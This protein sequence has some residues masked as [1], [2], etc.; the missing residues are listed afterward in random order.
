M[1]H[2]LRSLLTMLGVVFGVG[3]V[4]AMLAVGE[5]ANAEALKQIRELGSNNIIL[6]S[7]KPRKERGNELEGEGAL[8][9][10]LTYD[11]LDRIKASMGHIK[12]IVP[13][14]FSERQGRLKRHYGDVR[15]VGA[16]PDWFNV[17]YRPLLAGR[18][19]TEMDVAMKNNVCVMTEEAAQRLLAM[20]HPLGEKVRLESQY[21]EVIGIIES[22]TAGGGAID[23]PNQPNDIIIPLNAYKET[24][25][26]FEIRVVAG[27][28][29]R[30]YVELNQIVIQVAEDY[31]VEPTARS[32]ENLVDRFHKDD[33][34]RMSVPLQLLQQAEKTKR[35]FNIVL[36]SIAGIS[37]LVGGIGIMN[38]MLAS[39]TE[40]TK[41]IGIRRAIG[42]R[43]SQIISQFLIETITLSVLGG[44]VGIGLG[45]AIPEAI[46]RF[47][48]MPTV[49][50]PGSVILSLAISVGVGVVFGLY[51]AVRA[52]RLDPIE[53]LRHQ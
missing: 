37:L 48:G 30:T 22:S 15:V 17:F 29:E 27:S 7:I 44:L 8:A 35:T 13:V 9:Y 20:E 34:F 11:D 10:G 6:T 26:D 40:R 49:I 32:V 46:E 52:A 39:V 51:P 36:G 19:F 45:M 47:A 25:G 43:Q 23:A 31:H 38:I 21:F 42:A 16:T 12:H 3:S 14:K 33:D 2:K 50:S 5:G 28:E 24:Y 41:E 4:I 53:A 18:V 1:L